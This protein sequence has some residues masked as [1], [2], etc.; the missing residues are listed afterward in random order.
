MLVI[1]LLGS[2]PVALDVLGLE[3]VVAVVVKLFDTVASVSRMLDMVSPLAE[4]IGSTALVVVI[5][6]DEANVLVIS[7][8]VA[9][10]T[11]LVVQI[12]PMHSVV[13]LLEVDSGNVVHSVV[14]SVSVLPGRV[15]NSCDWSEKETP[16]DKLNS[17]DVVSGTVC[18]LLVD[19][20]ESYGLVVRTVTP[21][22]NST[23]D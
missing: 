8:I 4:L 15:V 22:G 17:G 19:E 20:E 9:V 14:Y 6:L 2:V 5:R 11:D 12:S 18:E 1:E 10:A 16:L 7:G 13:Y 3:V 21:E 23:L